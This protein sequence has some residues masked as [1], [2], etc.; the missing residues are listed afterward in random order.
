MK[1]QINLCSPKFTHNSRI[2]GPHLSDRNL[3][4]FIFV[5][6]LILCC[7]CLVYA[8][9]PDVQQPA[10]DKEKIR[11]GWSIS[12]MRLER[13]QSDCDAFQQRAK[14]LGA[15]VIVKDGQGDQDKWLRQSQEIL[16]SGI[17]VLVLVGG[18][19]KTEAEIT[20]AAK[21][22]NVKV[23]TY[24]SSVSGSE[25]LNIVTDY[26]SIGRLQVFTLTDRAPTG[27]Y[28]ILG[29]P[30]EQSGAFHG[31]QLEAL[32]PFLNDGR[33]KL[34]ADLNV[35]E[36]S[37]SEAYIDMARVLESNHNNITAVVATNDS[38]ASGA[39][40]ALEEHGLAGKVLVSGQDADLSA[41]VRI[42]LGTQT[43]TLYKPITPQALAAAEAA[44]SLARG[45]PVKTN[46]DSKIGTIRVPAF[47]FQPV[48][49]TKDNVKETVIKDGFQKVKEIKEGL[50]KEK[51]SLIE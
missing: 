14:A 38:I 45:V 42:L 12:D 20:R 51:W 44:V 21:A 36:W 6:A 37:A 41:I 16:A 22:R 13:W 9:T 8:Q 23:I 4:R 2:G 33:I 25:D 15:E 43:M 40:Q 27:N 3:H 19:P 31:S 17:Q 24:E 28:V 50:P 29:G 11:I 48:V 46:G 49:V 10:K 7:A 34:V 1:F 18:D 39:I 32:Q 47:F 26:S 30:A 35:A 5:V